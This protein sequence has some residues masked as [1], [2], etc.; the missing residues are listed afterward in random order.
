M[1]FC[2]NC[3]NAYNLTKTVKD[4][5]A[6]A[7]VTA[8]IPDEQTGGKS[9]KKRKKKKKSPQ[10]NRD[11]DFELAMQAQEDVE[12]NSIEDLIDKILSKVEIDPKAVQEFDLDS[13]TKKSKYKKLSASDKEL[14]T[15]TLQELLPKSKKKIY[16]LDAV[17]KTGQDAFF[18]CPN[19]GYY[20]KIK[21]KTLIYSKTVDRQDQD[22]L[23]ED[24]SDMCNDPTLPRTK[25][26]NCQNKKCITHSKP[27]KKEAV[28]FRLHNSFKLVYVCCACEAGWNHTA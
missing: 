11:D 10:Q 13:V 7:E 24:Y 22:I 18:L 8:E 26:Y 14:V 4:T 27:E 2:I 28:F 23:L 1:F 16:H 6:M 5:T 15:N 9:D 20:E 25:S 19:C 3:N 12:V 21:P 17:E